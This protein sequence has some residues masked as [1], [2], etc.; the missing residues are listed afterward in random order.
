MTGMPVTGQSRPGGSITCDKVCVVEIPTGDL[1]VGP[2]SGQ[3][4]DDSGIT[5]LLSLYPN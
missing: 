1:L 4:P 3:A 5:G 2:G